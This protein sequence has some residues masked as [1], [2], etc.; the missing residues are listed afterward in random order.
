MYNKGL[1]AML[2]GHPEIFLIYRRNG[3]YVKFLDI[4]KILLRDLKSKAK[5]FRDIEY[6]PRLE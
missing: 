5:L 1:G 4:M 2:L 6:L 3:A